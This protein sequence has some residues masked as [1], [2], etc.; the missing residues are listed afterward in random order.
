VSKLFVYGTLRNRPNNPLTDR[1][2]ARTRGR[3]YH[4]G[5]FPGL[6]ESEDP[7]DQVIGELMEV[8]DGRLAGLDLYEGY[9][10]YDLENSLYIRK[11]VEVFN[12]ETQ[13]TEMAWIYIFNQTSPWREHWVRIESGD[14]FKPN[15]NRA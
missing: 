11:K 6:L 13:E 14:W 3:L 10:S 1:V 7:Q 9:I 5:N 8:D 12:E 4:L 2:R 15:E